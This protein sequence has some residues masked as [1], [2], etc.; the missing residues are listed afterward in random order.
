LVGFSKELS[1]HLL[2]Y[3]TTKIQK[4]NNDLSFPG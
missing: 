2:Y 1:Y 3:K 4:E